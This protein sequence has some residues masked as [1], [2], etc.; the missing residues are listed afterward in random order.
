M[1]V[2]ER[3]QSGDVS[4]FEALFHQYYRSVF[5]TALIMLGT[6]DEAEDALQEIFVA[7][8]RSRS[9][10]DPARGGLSTWLHRIA[11]NHCASRRRTRRAATVPLEEATEAHF[12]RQWPA[13]PDSPEEL[14]MSQWEHERMMAAIG[15]LDERQ[16][17]VLV[18]RYYGE[19]SYQEIA[20]AL[21]IPLGTV[22]SRLSQ[23]LRGLRR[24]LVAE[25]QRCGEA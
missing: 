3:W 20:Q 23:A 5:T 25:G 8:W 2:I 9:T 10:F 12:E 22:K 14:A 7:M 19:L 13:H 21:D 11:I 6:R 4:A 15:S 1:D 17:S 16:R 18:L 24:L